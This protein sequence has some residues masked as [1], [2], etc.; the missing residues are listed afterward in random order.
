MDGS[1][2]CLQ[3]LTSVIFKEKILT[4]KKKKDLCRQS[5]RIREPDASAAT[6]EAGEAVDEGTEQLEKQNSWKNRTGMLKRIKG[7]SKADSHV[8]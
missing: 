3:V 2:R 8:I 6:Q 5:D 1:P 4:Y 7:A